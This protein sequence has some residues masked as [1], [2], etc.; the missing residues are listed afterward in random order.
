MNNFN[1]VFTTIKKY[2]HEKEVP[3]HT[4]F[5]E[6]EKMTQSNKVFFSVNLYLQT[7]EDI[8]LIKFNPST[9]TISITEKGMNTCRLFDN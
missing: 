3:S 1:A 6:L 2:C 7:L 4:C 8:G 5:K 9:K